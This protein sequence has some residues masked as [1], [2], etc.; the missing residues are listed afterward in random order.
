MPRTV[1]TLS[2]AMM[3]PLKVEPNCTFPPF[4]RG[5]IIIIDHH[6]RTFVIREANH[7]QRTVSNNSTMK[8]AT[9]LSFV[10]T[11]GVASGFAPISSR[12]TALSQLAMSTSAEAA[13]L[14]KGER[15]VIF[16]ADEASYLHWL[17]SHRSFTTSLE[18]C[19]LS[20]QRCMSTIIVHSASV[21]VWHSGSRT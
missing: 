16:L 18:L 4:F 20:S 5:I 2:M 17:T 21:S 12:S 7:H 11:A 3:R 15:F 9:V 1:D 13:P 14:V 19:A 10:L 6:H 8:L